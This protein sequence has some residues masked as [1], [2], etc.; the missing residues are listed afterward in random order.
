MPGLH[1][2]SISKSSISNSS[3]SISSI[4]ADYSE[5]VSPDIE[6][7]SPELKTAKTV[8]NFFHIEKYLSDYWSKHIEVN[9]EEELNVRKVDD[10]VHQLIHL[11][12]VIGEKEPKK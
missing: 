4:S 11:L 2:L 1:G 10:A 12:L 5:E 8:D 3:A 6:I 9:E 7:N